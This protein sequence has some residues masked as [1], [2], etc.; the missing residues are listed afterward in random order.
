MTFCYINILRE[1]RRSKD[2][3]ERA[4]NLSS[5][6]SS[7]TALTPAH[8]SDN[9]SSSQTAL[10]DT[11]SAPNTPRDVLDTPKRA[12]R[13]GKLR[14]LFASG[15]SSSRS[16]AKAIQY[17]VSDIDGLATSPDKSSVISSGGYAREAAKKRRERRRREELRL[18]TS[19]F[20]VIV[21]F[22]ICW[23]PFC[24]TMFLN[25]F[26]NEPVPRIPDVTTMLLGCLNS[27]CNPIIYG[28]MNRK[29]RSGFARIYCGLCRMVRTR[30]S[31]QAQTSSSFPKSSSSEP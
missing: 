16:D 21:I 26:G 6:I 31:S 19:L 9:K 2:R 28:L 29:F 5:R 24:I 8:S 17:T 11:L 18:T 23:F 25:V 13:M 27:C 10:T 12:K 15:D 4:Q 1:V 30:K 3:I 22:T 14:A 20:V 7:P